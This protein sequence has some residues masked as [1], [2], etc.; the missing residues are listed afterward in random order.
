MR[1]KKELDGTEMVDTAKAICQTTAEGSLAI[2]WTTI[3]V[4]KKRT[5]HSCGYSVDGSLISASVVPQRRYCAVNREGHVRTNF[6]TSQNQSY[7]L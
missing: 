3:E 2:L 7:Y 5:F 1:K 4:F 6:N